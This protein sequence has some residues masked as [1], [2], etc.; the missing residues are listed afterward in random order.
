MD[1]VGPLS[2]THSGNRF[3]LVIVD[4]F[5]KWV[6]TLLIRNI[7]AKIVVE[8]FVREIISRNG[9]PSEI[10]TDQGRNFESKLFLKLTELLGIKKK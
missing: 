7:R 8:V 4:C 2:K 6:E 10:H 9:V 3:V 5:T 1:V